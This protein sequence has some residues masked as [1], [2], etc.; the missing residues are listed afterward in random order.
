MDNKR[1]ANVPLPDN[2]EARFRC[3]RN[4]LRNWNFEGYIV[5]KPRV[6]EWLRTELPEYPW[7]EIR[8]Q[9]YEHV[10]KGGA[11]DEQVERR[12][13]YVH[14]GFHYDLR[15]GMGNRNVYFETVLLCENADDPDDPQIIIV[16]V[17]DV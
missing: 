6:E 2:R 14:Y 9:L 5:L 17:H 12:P 16:S 10:E 7:R 4:A 8:R 1:N 13:E 11:I 3:F 15:L